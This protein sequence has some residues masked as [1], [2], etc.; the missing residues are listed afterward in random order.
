MVRQ[1][2][3]MLR[4]MMDMGRDP[5]AE[6]AQAREQ[7]TA[8]AERSKVAAVTLREVANHYIA[9]KKTRNGPL[10]A[11]TIRD[12]NAH[13]DRSFGTWALRPIASITRDMCEAR[14]KEL[15]TGGLTGKRAAPHR[16]R[17]GFIVLRALI[18]WA[19]D[20]YRVDG[21]RLIDENPVNVLRGQMA[22]PNARDMRVPTERVGHVWEALREVRATPARPS[23]HTQADALAFMLITGGRESEVTDLTWD[24]VQLQDD[25]GSWHLPDPKNGRAVTFPL[26]APARALLAARPRRKGC[27]Y[28]F[29]AA[30]GNKPIGIPRGEPMRAVIAAA[31]CPQNRHSLRATFSTLAHNVLRIEHT[32]VELITGHEPTSVTLRHYVETNDLRWAAHEV[33]RIGAW[34]VEQADIAAGR[35]VVKMPEKK[36]A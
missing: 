4:N 25:A 23:T 2:A 27:D 8:N 19:M 18:N 29:P 36:R 30:K 22:P 10:K 21:K 15:A 6:Q 17:G 31:G 3:R 32:V 20:K 1:R 33:E 24:R 13:V 35:N 26:S 12:I 14:H 5:L 7:V 9:N 16:A 11:N 34:I 28:V